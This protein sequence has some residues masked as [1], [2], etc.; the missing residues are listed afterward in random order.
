VRPIIEE[1]AEDISEMDYEN[2][3]TRFKPRNTFVAFRNIPKNK[4]KTSLKDFEKLRR[5]TTV[6]GLNE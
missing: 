5:N 3:S 2:P 1:E 6:S 4:M